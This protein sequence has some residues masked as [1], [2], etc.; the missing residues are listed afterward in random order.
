MESRAPAGMKTP[1]KKKPIWKRAW[2][3]LGGI[4]I[5]FLVFAF[6]DGDN[7]LTH[8]PDDAEII[9]RVR[10][11][12]EALEE[13]EKSEAAKEAL[14]RFK[15]NDT[16]AVLGNERTEKLLRWFGRDILI[17]K[18]GE[19][20][21]REVILAKIGPV[22]KMADLFGLAPRGCER[23]KFNELSYRTLNTS[24]G[25]LCYSRVGRTLM[26]ARTPERLAEVSSNRRL[27]SLA[28]FIEGR[29][30]K[31]SIRIVVDN[32]KGG[33]A[34]ARWL[35]L[36]E[37]ETKSARRLAAALRA[38]EQVGV[39]LLLEP[40]MRGK[41]KV[42]L[43]R[44]AR[45]ILKPNESSFECKFESLSLIPEDVLAAFSICGDDSLADIFS[46]GDKSVSVILPRK[47]NDVLEDVEDATGITPD[48]IARRHLGREATVALSSLSASENNVR[49][50]FLIS[51]DGKLTPLVKLYQTS[52]L[53]QKRKRGRILETTGK[54]GEKI[55]YLSGKKGLAQEPSF[56]HIEPLDILAS[57]RPDLARALEA[58]FSSRS[59]TN[60]EPMKEISRQARAILY[61][62]G[63][64]ISEAKEEIL[65]LV[66][67]EKWLDEGNVEESLVPMLEGLSKLK[68]AALSM[69]YEGNYLRGKIYLE[70]K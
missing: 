17:V 27:S 64:E 1:A 57:D 55:Y 3:Y 18:S 5:G 68:K 12:R 8:L 40:E 21:S 59:L 42:A 20:R 50:Q 37:K 66:N 51:L 33:G 23:R 7:F 36:N 49:A 28:G 44:E 54:S 22:L 32:S 63:Q 70:L 41:Y 53:F 15:V 61:L 56:C 6:W 2:L 26:V 30:P 46:S 43:S 45:R 38:V 16:G 14:E 25:I 48:E 35:K 58:K 29:M 10:D 11:V 13:L 39:E 65:K 60:W 24:Q 34:F 52:L 19:D 9:I 47:V 31:K 67:K 69:R 62:N 4:I